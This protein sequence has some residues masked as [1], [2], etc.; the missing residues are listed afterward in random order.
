M[1]ASGRMDSLVIGL[2]VN[3]TVATG[4]KPKKSL[5]LLA[6]SGSAENAMNAGKQ[7]VQRPVGAKNKGLFQNKSKAVLPMVV[8]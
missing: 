5:I 8:P 6:S 4:A 3:A 7:D 2:S 1:R